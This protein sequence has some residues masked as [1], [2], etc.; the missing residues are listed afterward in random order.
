MGLDIKVVITHSD[1]GGFG[2]RSCGNVENWRS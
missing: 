2:G 1:F